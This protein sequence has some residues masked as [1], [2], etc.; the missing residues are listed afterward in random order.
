MRD[1][2][3]LRAVQPGEPSPA[4]PHP[5]AHLLPAYA[6]AA[7]ALRRLGQPLPEADRERA[8]RALESARASHHAGQPLATRCDL[9][10]QLARDLGAEPLP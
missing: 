2:S 9:V 1:L 3:Q 6:W 7:D 8:R 5:W 4:D 10:D